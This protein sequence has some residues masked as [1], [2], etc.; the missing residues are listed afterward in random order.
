[1]GQRIAGLK[2]EYGVEHLVRSRDVALRILAGEKHDP[3]IQ[4]ACETRHP[5]DVLRF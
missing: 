4:S 3:R 2:G 5:A 1:M